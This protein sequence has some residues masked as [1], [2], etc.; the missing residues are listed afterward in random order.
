MSVRTADAAH[1]SSD[2]RAWSDGCALPPT[3][4]LCTSPGTSFGDEPERGP[5]EQAMREL[6]WTDA[7]GEA[8][9]PPLTAAEGRKL[10][11][12]LLQVHVPVNTDRLSQPK[13][14]WWYGSHIDAFYPPTPTGSPE[15]FL[16]SRVAGLQSATRKG[17]RDVY[18]ASGSSVLLMMP[19]NQ[20]YVVF[21]APR[22]E[23][24]AVNE[25]PPEEDD[26][27]DP[28]S[29]QRLGR[30]VETV[31]VGMDDAPP[32]ENGT[33][34]TKGDSF[35][36]RRAATGTRAPFAQ[37]S[38]RPRDERR[39]A[40]L[41]RKDGAPSSFSDVA[42][43]SAVDLAVTPTDDFP[44][45]N[46]NG[47]QLTHLEV[48]RRSP[49]ECLSAC[50][51]TLAIAPRA[52]AMSSLLSMVGESAPQYPS[53]TKQVSKLLGSCSSIFETKL[54]ARSYPNGFPS[55]SDSGKVPTASPPPHP[56]Q[57]PTRSKSPSPLTGRKRRMVSPPPPFKSLSAAF[58][59]G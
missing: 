24:C 3:A 8:D 36:A 40:P 31:Q 44:Q 32:D 54:P 6:E 34:E 37:G 59:C 45:F 15:T 12:R 13:E 41:P 17:T 4:G 21:E 2:T 57:E 19:L 52:A 9:Q 26:D 22:S 20:L 7:D 47:H 30:L 16:G 1:W 14:W 53:S 58:F 35:D 28:T 25:P 29:W 39:L 11:G 56:S 48:R 33:T 18:G 51:A 23:D 55:S 49:L 27:D 50:A 46:E 43:A 5:L 38:G 10:A 42:A